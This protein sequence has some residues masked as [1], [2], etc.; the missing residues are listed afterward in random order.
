MRVEKTSM[1]WVRKAELFQTT[2]QESREEG[3]EKW[4]G[5]WGVSSTTT[6]GAPRGLEEKE[7]SKL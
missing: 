5:E 2:W 3:E 7:E 1:R 4:R 6:Y